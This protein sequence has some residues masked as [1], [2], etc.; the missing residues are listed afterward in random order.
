MIYFL[1]GCSH[2][3]YNTR[4][5]LGSLLYFVKHHE[6]IRYTNVTKSE[7]TNERRNVMAAIGD[8]IVFLALL[9]DQVK[10]GYRM[11]VMNG[12]AERN[13]F[14]A[15]CKSNLTLEKNSRV[16]F[17]AICL[18]SCGKEDEGCTEQWMILSTDT[19]GLYT[20]KIIFK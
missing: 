2:L 7:K 20:D 13:V 8:R 18:Y 15:K 5:R 1:V 4:R 3:C 12:P 19:P 14:T 16:E 10:E 11:I 6:S 9:L 17:E